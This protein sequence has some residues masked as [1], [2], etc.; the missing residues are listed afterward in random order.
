MLQLKGRARISNAV[1]RYGLTVPHRLNRE[2]DR[3]N[4]GTLSRRSANW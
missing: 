3:G 1:N 2:A 4:P